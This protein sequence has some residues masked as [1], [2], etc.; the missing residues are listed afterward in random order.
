MI[1]SMVA[2]TL[3]AAEPVT[4]PGPDGPLAGSLEA[5]TGTGK[6]PAVVIIPGSGPTD[7]DGNSP[8]GI[9][10]GSYRLLAE[11]LAK[12]GATSIRIDKRG[13]F[14]S[15]AA[16]ADGNAATVADYA[17]DARVWAAL[18]AKRA[19][20]RCAWLVGHSEGGLVALVAAQQARDL[21]GVVL[22][23]APGRRIV[24]VMR[25]QFAANP[26]NAPILSDATRMLDAVE[27]GGTVTDL[28]PPL[29]TMFPLAVQS[30]LGRLN[31]YD[32]A[33]LARSAVVP[34]VVV[35]GDADLQVP[36]AD[37]QRLAGA[38]PKAQLVVVP[39]VNHVLKRTGSDRS[40][41]LRSYADVS[42]PID[43]GVVAAVAAGIGAR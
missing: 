43:E 35:Q 24:D 4:V 14:G 6:G 41:N 30:Y 29:S 39:G 38:N 10:A 17:A 8:L 19:G 20:T 23:S 1:A 33:A 13:M 22:L 9:T 31:A 32:P 37:A 28:P 12:R 16:S 21:C 34:I 15:R 18:A 7:R 40:A 36:V 11:A 42:L 3:A 26:A 5:G 2:L 27:K 25:D